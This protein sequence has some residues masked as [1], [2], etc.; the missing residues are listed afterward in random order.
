MKWFFGFVC[1]SIILQVITFFIMK[2]SPSDVE[3]FGE[4]LE[5]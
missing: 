2:N 4:E 5:D 3:L 1:F